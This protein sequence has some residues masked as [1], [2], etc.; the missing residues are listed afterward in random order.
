[1]IRSRLRERT[2][3]LKRSVKRV[4]VRA[5][6]YGPRPL[7]TA[8]PLPP[9]PLQLEIYSIYA[10]NI[11]TELVEAQAAVFRH[12]GLPLI[13]VPFGGDER[14]D[15]V[16]HRG[17]GEAIQTL[18]R[19]S[20][21]DLLILFDIDCIPLHRH[22]LE[23]CYLPV[24]QAGGL[25]GPAQRANHLNRLI[26]A[27]PSAIGFSR[28]LYRRVGQPE[29]T[30]SKRFDVGGSLT[31]ACARRGVPVVKLPPLSCEVPKWPLDDDK[32]LSYGHGTTYVGGIYHAFEIRLGSTQERFLRKCHEV[33]RGPGSSGGL[34][35]VGALP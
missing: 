1:M 4:L 30:P 15:R 28:E 18:A 7:P 5:G 33:L 12:L 34:E 17:H 29:L 22:V 23:H 32:R 14:D 13:Q 16:L 3:L 24:M 21:A 26:Y 11:A 2:V 6:W 25:V 10:H 20:Q 8:G 27:A 9:R 19:Q 31:W 35:V